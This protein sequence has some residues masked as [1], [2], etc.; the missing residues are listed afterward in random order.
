DERQ[1][2]Q[3]ASGGGSRTNFGGYAPGREYVEFDEGTGVL[4][5]KDM[6]FMVQFHYTA[7]GRPVVDVTRIGLYFH[8]KPPALPL[9]RTAV[10]NGEFVIPPGVEDYPVIARA[11][12]ARDSY[13]YNLA[14]HIHYRCK[15]VK[16]SAE[17][18]DGTVE[19]ILSIPHFQHNWQMIFRL[20]EPKFLPAGTVIVA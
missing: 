12:I 1:Q 5:Q 16:Y 7:I 13:L 9:A 2:R 18:P 20:H 10:M 17:Y 19:D 3:N 4:L 6:R 15:R 11:T 8:D 14:P